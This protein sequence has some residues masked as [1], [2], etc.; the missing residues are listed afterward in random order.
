MQREDRI[1]EHTIIRSKAHVLGP[2]VSVSQIPKDDEAAKEGNT[3]ED[4]EQYTLAPED[5]T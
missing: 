5:T 4:I 3:N 1:S 2:S